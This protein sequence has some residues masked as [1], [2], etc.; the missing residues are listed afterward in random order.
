MYAIMN[1]VDS[2]AKGIGGIYG[3]FISPKGKRAFGK[4]V[5][6]GTLGNRTMYAQAYFL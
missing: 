2:N 3:N 5:C 6:L 4:S 1:K